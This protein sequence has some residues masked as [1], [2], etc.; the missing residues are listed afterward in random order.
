[1]YKAMKIIRIIRTILLYIF[2]I[3][4]CIQFGINFYLFF[5]KTTI[6]KKTFANTK[7]KII[8]VYYIFP[9]ILYIK[10]LKLSNL[11][12]DLELKNIFLNL[13]LVEIFKGRTGISFLQV[14]SS[15]INIINLKTSPGQETQFPQQF[16]INEILKKLPNKFNFKN[17]VVKYNNISVVLE[18]LK[19][20]KYK[21]KIEISFNGSW[22]EFNFKT[23]ISADILNNKWRGLLKAYFSDTKFL[24]VLTNPS[25]ILQ[26]DGEL[27]FTQIQN[28]ILEISV[29]KQPYKLVGQLKFYPFEVNGKF[30]G[31]KN[32]TGD[33]NILSQNGVLTANYKGV[34]NVADIIGKDVLKPKLNNVNTEFFYLKSASEY[35]FFINFSNQ[36][37][38]VKVNLD[39]NNGNFYVVFDKNHI[40]G[41][42]IYNE[43]NKLL[44]TISKNKDVPFN[45]SFLFDEK[46]HIKAEGIIL[47]YKTFFDLNYKD[48]IK[49]LCEISSKEV[50][51]TC[52]YFHKNINIK[53][54]NFAT[55]SELL[56]NIFATDD[57]LKSFN[58]NINSKNLKIKRKFSFVSNG[59]IIQKDK[60]SNEYEL[61]AQIRNL[62]VDNI[63]L[64][65]TANFFGSFVKNILSFN[66]ISDD[67]SIIVK[68]NWDSAQN[69][70]NLETNI[71]KNNFELGKIKLDFYSK[72]KI[73][74]IKNWSVFGS[75]DFKNIYYY[76]NYLITS[77]TGNLNSDISKVIFKGQLIYKQ[78]SYGYELIIPNEGNSGILKLMNISLFSKNINNAEKFN[79][80]FNFNT[81]FLR[82]SELKIFGKIYNDNSELN[83]DSF[84]YLINKGII[85]SKSK[86]KNFNIY[87]NYIIGDADIVIQQRN[88][89]IVSTVTFQNLWINNYVVDNLYIQC[90]YDTYKRKFS[91]IPAYL[92][93]KNFTTSSGSLNLLDSSV[94]FE[95]FKIYN[96]LGQS[97]ILDGTLGQHNNILN[98]KFDKIPLKIASG[99]LNINKI[100]IDGLLS[101]NLRVFS[102]SQNKK[103]IKYI[104]SS[105]FIINDINFYNLKINYVSGQINN[106]ESYI[107]LE[108]LNIVFDKKQKITVKGKYNPEDKSLNFNINSSNCSL[109]I[110]NNFYGIVDKAQGGFV[111]DLSL[112]GDTSSP[113]LYG[114]VEVKNGQISFYKYLKYIENLNCKVGFLGDNINIEKFV[115]YY[116]KTKITLSGN[117]KINN[118]YNFKLKTEGGSGVYVSIPE[119]SL[120]LD[121]FL[122][123]VKGNASYGDLHFNL[124][125]KK[126]AGLPFLY[127]NVFMNNTYFTYPG[128]YKSKEKSPNF[129]Y[130]ITLIANDN[131][132]YKN[133]LILAN[134]TGKINLKCI[135]NSSTANGEIQSVKGNVSFL[136]AQLDIKSGTLEIINKE[137]YLEIIGETEVVTPEKEKIKIQLIV[138]RAKLSEIK[139]KLTSPT[140]PELKTEDITAIMLGIGKL[141]KEGEKVSVIASER[142][143]SLSLLRTQIIRIIS[144]TVATPIAKNLLQKWNIAD[145]ITITQIDTGFASKKVSEGNNNQPEQGTVRV[146]DIF[147]N[148]KYGIEKYLTPDMIIGYSIAL[149]EYQNK[150]N[151]KHEFEISYRLRNNI[152]I[153]GI[154]GYGLQDYATGRYGSDVKIQIEPKFKFKSWAEEE[155]EEKEENK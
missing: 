86:F 84:V 154:Y 58:F 79:A 81:D 17:F 15:N 139:P 8:G 146:I 48:D 88:E 119:L 92:K 20:I 76:K 72:I 136:N 37:F 41:D 36:S 122:K 87:N 130:D 135:N 55:S 123:F 29:I 142:I 98:I 153:K 49:I 35:K 102:S 24:K 85:Q 93:N 22:K 105:S 51:F 104:F 126:Q 108:D 133:E 7:S 69:I 33:I 109:S 128:N 70:F 78:N 38:K 113:K 99:L 46:D 121:S 53:Y 43:N 40:L 21:N 67:N 134:I 62:Y 100:D 111:L 127:G 45:L 106:F 54:R 9:N 138:P 117:Y 6:L 152:F 57:N 120:P 64:F 112:K 95:N 149:A 151:L 5:N 44:K 31:G 129:L 56:A 141:K 23:G 16:Q 68:G 110:V 1:M 145:N 13:N 115:G 25:L 94:K 125:L 32:I 118:N 12:T 96:N 47:K 97:V 65:N 11:Q 77:I 83:I 82:K 60:L 73:S 30:I 148:T 103:I 140:Y 2:V 61:N 63:K 137:V 75:Y 3:I 74:K 14:S 144:T 59:K 101:A 42:I 124:N 90:L 131:V 19:G 89:I 34:A 132:W 4:L 91:F 66:I 150:L 71:N 18:N 80:E 28:F 116:D 52:E 27:D 143:D 114:Y 39:N 50:N 155:K 26:I 107:N 147:K 10:S